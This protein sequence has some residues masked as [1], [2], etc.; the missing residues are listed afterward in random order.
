VDDFACRRGHT[1]GSVV[2]DMDTR[3]PVDVLPDRLTDSALI[4]AQR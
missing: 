2:I 3:R 4:R 1:Y